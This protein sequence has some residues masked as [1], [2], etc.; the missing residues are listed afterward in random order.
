[1]LEASA[2]G[3]ARCVAGYKRRGILFRVGASIVIA[4]QK[5]R[6]AVWRKM[7]RQSMRK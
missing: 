4:G 2:A 6:S 1:V 3:I 5:A 7:T